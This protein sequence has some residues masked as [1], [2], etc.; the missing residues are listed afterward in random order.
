MMRHNIIR[1]DSQ[2]Q[3]LLKKINFKPL[4]LHKSNLFEFLRFELYDIMP[5]YYWHPNN[6]VMPH[7]FG[8]IL[9]QINKLP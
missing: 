6:P 3:V 5:L 9:K 2:I 8:T 7:Y 4:D 1:Y